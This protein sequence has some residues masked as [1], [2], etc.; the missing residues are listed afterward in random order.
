MA[1]PDRLDKRPTAT[2]PASPHAAST[3]PSP[4]T[5]TTEKDASATSTGSKP[6][7]TTASPKRRTRGSVFLA[8]IRQT[9]YELRRLQCSQT[10]CSTFSFQ[11]QSF[12]SPSIVCFHCTACSKFLGL[13]FEFAKCS[14]RT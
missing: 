4:A 13:L 3:R 1:T 6:K 7:H 12:E 10:R 9:Q 11:D 8:M 14:R 2:A 5:G